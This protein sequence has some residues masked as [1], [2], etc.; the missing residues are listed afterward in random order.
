MGSMNLYS[1]ALSFVLNDLEKGHSLHSV[2][3]TMIA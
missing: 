2:T 1:A 3:F